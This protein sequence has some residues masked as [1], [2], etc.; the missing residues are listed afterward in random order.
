MDISKLSNDPSYQKALQDIEAFKGGASNAP[1]MM[2]QDAGNVYLNP[3]IPQNAKDAL[4]QLLQD[5]LQDAV[6]QNPG[7]ASFA[8]QYEYQ[9][10]STYLQFLPPDDMPP[11]ARS[12]KGE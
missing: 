12:T 5:T 6:K 9:D 1:D 2:I 3:N 7:W 8:T 4:H 10:T 11:M